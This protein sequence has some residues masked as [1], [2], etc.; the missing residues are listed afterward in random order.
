M[1]MPG[2]KKLRKFWNEKART[3]VLSGVVIALMLTVA[4][5][6]FL[7]ILPKNTSAAWWDN[8]WQYYRVCNIN[9]SGYSGNYQMRINV[10][11]SSGGDVDCGGHCQADFDDI[12]FVDLD[13]STELPYWRETYVSSNYAIFWVNVSADA[14][15]DGKI[16]M[17]YGND[18]ATDASDGNATFI[19]YNDGTGTTGWTTW[20]GSPNITTDGDYLDIHTTSPEERARIYVSGVSISEGALLRT[21]YKQYSSDV[22][23]QRIGFLNPEAEDFEYN[24]VDAYDSDTSPD[25]S[26]RFRSSKDGTSTYVDISGA[27]DFYNFH[28]YETAWYNDSGTDT[29]K[30]WY[31]GTLKSTKTNNIPTVD[32]HVGILTDYPP[33]GLLIDYITVGKYASTEPIW[34]SFSDEQTQSGNHIPSISNPYPGDSAM[35]F[36]VVPPS[37]FSITVSDADG[38]SMSITWQ[39]NSSGTWKTFNTTANAADGIYYAYNTSWASGYNTT[40]FWKVIVDDGNDTAYRIYK[41]T[42]YGGLQKISIIGQVRGITEVRM[43]PEL[44]YIPEKNISY[45]VYFG[46]NWEVYIT[47]Y[48]HT[49]GVWANPVQI[50]TVSADVHYAPVIMVNSS[51][52]IYVW[53]G[54]HNTESELAIS[55]N[56]YDISSWTTTTWG[57]SMTYPL[58]IRLTNGTIF[59]FYRDYDSFNDRSYCYKISYDDGNTWTEE[60]EFIQTTDG[61]YGE[62]YLGDVFYYNDR[63]YFV[64]LD[65]KH[66]NSDIRRDVFC[67]YMNLS[68]RH[69]YD[70]L[71]NDV[72]IT[73]NYT[74]MNDSANYRFLVYNSRDP[75]T[76]E[77]DRATLYIRISVYN[78]IPYITF[79]NDN[80]IELRIL[81]TYWNGSGWQL[82]IKIT[83]VLDPIRPSYL[84]VKNPTYMDCY[85]SK[86]GI[87]KWHFNGNTWSKEK[88]ILYDADDT[89]H[90]FRFPWNVTGKKLYDKKF[91]GV[92]SSYADDV[93][94]IYV[95]S[96][97]PTNSPPAVSN[98]SPANG[99]SGIELNPDLY[100][101]LNDQ[102]NDT[103]NIMVRT[104]AS[105]SWQ[106]LA[107]SSGNNGTYSVTANTVFNSYNTKYWWS[108]NVTDGTSWTNETFEFTTITNNSPPTVSITSPT[109]GATVNGTVTITGT[110]SDSDGTVQSVEVKIGSDAWATA[111]GTTSWTFTWDTT[112]YSDGSY[113]ILARSYDGTDYSTEAQV[114]VTINNTDPSTNHAP[115]ITLNSPGNGSTDVDIN[116][117]LN[118]TVSD[119]DGDNMTITFWNYTGS[120]WI[121]WGQLVNKPNGTYSFNPTGDFAYNTTYT[122]RASVNDSTTS[123]NS[124]AWTFTT[125]AEAATPNQPPTANF[126][127]TADDLTVSFTDSSTDSDGNIT[128]WNWSFGDDQ[129]STAQN[130]THAYA[131]GGAYTVTLTVT[132][133]NGTTDTI[134]KSVTVSTGSSNWDQ[135][136]LYQYFWY[137]IGILIFLFLVVFLGL[138]RRGR[139]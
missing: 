105:G 129:F 135:S 10:T 139:K 134:S 29:G 35:Q 16:L 30:F 85:I 2:K 51:G 81:F 115:T 87:E 84:Y 94:Y 37:H 93:G 14:M 42:T 125:A 43:N 120:E 73:I 41:F 95:Y 82:P 97:P 86:N 27:P 104:N 44:L 111:S 40:Y 127:W 108:V 91:L 66:I 68:N 25:Y 123:N 74:E 1:K 32:L 117:S 79:T 114:N 53:Y 5:M 13:N 98:P 101:T 23:A 45:L 61:G 112:G 89:R 49:T 70:M 136:S 3:Q 34:D 90:Y 63:I 102:E 121:E 131:V 133:N 78:G 138:I 15:S 58:V 92:I 4:M 55:N 6:G 137:F 19:Y 48:N 69:M 107:T 17:Y 119:P 36:G 110:A 76:T 77:S 9:A 75:I 39:E 130:P 126:T 24:S 8:N 109:E 28:T 64:W 99:S 12:R 31:D 106:T 20:G 57:P 67:A 33:N 50:D 122:W 116:V 88:T 21:R 96:E 54:S 71:D 80:D 46:Q 60:T 38:D 124:E 65:A 59:A 128:S 72:G 18:I 62:V 26:W 56:P 113:T 118:V 7:V 103:M 11:Y 83:T 100:F 132:D 47:Y 22:N 52:Y